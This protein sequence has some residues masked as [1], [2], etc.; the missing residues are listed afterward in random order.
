MST[1][2][3]IPAR[4][5]SKG[6]PRKNLM[7]VAGRPLIAWTIEQA[8]AARHVDR[9]IVSTDCEEIAAVARD[10]GAEVPFLRPAAFATDQAST[11]SVLLHAL[12][13]L[14]ASGYQP[15]LVVLLQ[16]TCP[17]RRPG[18]ID[19]AIA[20]LREAGADS[21]VSVREI[22]PFLWRNPDRATAT[23]DYTRRPRRQ[24][25]REEERLFEEN[26]SIYVTRTHTLRTL[27]NRLGGH[28]A[29]FPMDRS[30]SVDIDT[31]D[32]VRL[33]EK[34]LQDFNLQ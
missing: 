1:L 11:E 3:I 34:L 4:G 19:A 25:L 5:G 10:C 28:I 29:L 8:L 30:E 18:R 24:D 12:E 26:G 33:A 32:D 17:V 22:H 21:L 2:A 16:A 7:P 9:T 14:D 6:I 31:A 23:Y 13:T 20:R 15:E 27:G